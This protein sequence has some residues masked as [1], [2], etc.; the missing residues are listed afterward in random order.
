MDERHRAGISH[1][2][3]L[4]V[5]PELLCK[6]GHGTTIGVRVLGC[7]EGEE[8]VEREEEGGAREGDGEGEGQ[9]EGE[10][11]EGKGRWGRLKVKYKYVIAYHISV[12]PATLFLRTMACR[13]W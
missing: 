13:R 3:L 1:T 10:S 8:G 6:L 11:E 9:A 4:L 12:C 5:K 2:H 7:N